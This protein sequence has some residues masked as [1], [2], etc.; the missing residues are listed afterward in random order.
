MDCLFCKI[1]SGEISSENVFEDE[2]V[3]AFLDIKPAAKGHTLVIPKKHVE[4]IWIMEDALLGRVMSK[5]RDIGNTLKK[6]LE[7]DFVE[8]RVIG[9]DVAHAHVHLIPQYNDEVQP[10][11]QGSYEEGEKKYWADKIKGRI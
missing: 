8:L 4:S 5:V 11:P 2:E 9:I 3:L 10:M 7:C 1:V 6:A